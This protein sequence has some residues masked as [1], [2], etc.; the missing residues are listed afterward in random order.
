MRELGDGIPG[1]R[2]PHHQLARYGPTAGMEGQ[3]L[4]GREAPL[5]SETLSEVD[6]AE[7]P[8]GGVPGRA[9]ARGIIRAAGNEPA[10]DNLLEKALSEQPLSV[11]ASEIPRT[12][13]RATVCPLE[14]G[15]SFQ[16]LR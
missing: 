7:L 15:K 16:G 5:R 2:R 13:R 3:G 9:L 4:F 12:N 1:F 6:R 14:L 11:C 8:V 10:L